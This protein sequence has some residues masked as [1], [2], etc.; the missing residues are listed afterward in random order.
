[1]SFD[2]ILYHSTRTQ[3][4]GD[5]HDVTPGWA[6]TGPRGVTVRSQAAARWQA[7]LGLAGPFAA[8]LLLPSPAGQVALLTDSR[9]D[10]VVG[11]IA[12]LVAIG[13]T[14]SL[15]AWSA[16]VCGVALLARVPGATG[17]AARRILGGIT[18][19]MI[20]RVVMTAAGLSVAAGLAA[21][22][23]S[24]ASGVTVPPSS[25]VSASPAASALPDV[26]LDWP[27][28]VTTEPSASEASTGVEALVPP[29]DTTDHAAAS[30]EDAIPTATTMSPA[31]AAAPNAEAPRTEPMSPADP[32][33]PG[34]TAIPATGSQTV[35]EGTAAPA[36]P[37]DSASAP[38]GVTVRPGD[39][40]WSI[41]ARSLPDNTSAARVD[42]AL[43]EWYQANRDV[44]GDDPNL[45]RPG[46]YLTAPTVMT[47]TEIPQGCSSKFLTR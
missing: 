8:A 42:A 14:W 2:V 29:I 40:L 21:C 25:A 20:R 9:P 37:S 7:A 3:R 18:P 32:P 15:A 28:T 6:A 22:G 36:A 24:A 33:T 38:S 43:R 34:T 1:M 16:T 17:M 31:P 44:I 10:V 13:V 5:T 39:S 23:T 45:I 12:V 41:A 4:C 35:P 27:I 19:T 26:D 11:A 30:D 46:Q 47:L